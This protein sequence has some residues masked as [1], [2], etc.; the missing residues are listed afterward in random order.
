[1][2]SLTVTDTKA[3]TESVMSALADEAADDEAENGLDLTRWHALQTWIAGASHRV[4]VPFA[5]ELSEMVPGLAVRLRRDFKAILN[6]I[7]AHALLHQATREVDER[8]RV[9]ATISGDYAPVHQ[10]V[11]EL[12]AAGVEA[13]VPRIVRETV[14]VVAD[15]IDTGD[16][17]EVRIAALCKPLEIDRTAAWRRARQALDRGYLKNLETGRGRP[18]RLVLGE[19]MPEDTP[20]LPSPEDLSSRCAV[21]RVQEGVYTPPP[22]LDLDGEPTQP[23]AE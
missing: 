1:M 13:T 2:L 9:L 14:D 11:A 4:I 7:R 19:P 18:A 15:L 6:L 3:Q 22:F 20:I 10:L 23:P 8:G 12:I 21:A 5:N 16:E 17:D